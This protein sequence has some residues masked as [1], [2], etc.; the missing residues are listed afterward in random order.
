MVLD[1]GIRTYS[2]SDTGLAEILDLHPQNLTCTDGVSLITPPDRIG[3]VFSGQISNF[4]S[5]PF[6]FCDIERRFVG[7]DA[8]RSLFG[9]RVQLQRGV[10]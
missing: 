1:P 5:K 6:C 3:F 4:S 8:D 9:A 10:L 7:W 2:C